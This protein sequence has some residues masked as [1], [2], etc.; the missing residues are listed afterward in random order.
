MATC[1]CGDYKLTVNGVTKP[2]VYPLPLVEDLFASLSGGKIFSKLDHTHT[3]QQVP[4]EEDSKKYTTIN[5]TKGLFQ[6]ECLPFGVSAA[7]AIFQRIMESLLQDL[8]RVTV[9]LDDIL[10]AG[11]NKEDHLAN[12]DRVMAR[13]KSAGLTLKKSK[14][15][16]GLS[17]IE[18][19][20][21]IIDAD[22]L[23]P[24]SNEVRAIKDA[25]EPKSLAELKSFGIT[26]L[27]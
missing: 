18:Y 10:V 1:V 26:Q 6:F 14:C 4:L 19:L 24:S 5:T 11:V 7:P 23:H 9:Y 27:L 3:Y 25:P 8:P 12:L 13:L 2:D 22:G 20:G 16:F 21:H 15:L 17:S